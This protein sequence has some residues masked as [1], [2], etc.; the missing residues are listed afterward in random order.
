MKESEI[1][2][3]LAKKL[4]LLDPSLS[5]VKEEY[6]IKLLDGRRG[7]IDILA[8][9]KYGCYT[10]IE[11]KKSNKSA[12]TTVQQMY[13]Y[14]SF[15]KEKNRLETSQI[16]LIVISTVWEELSSPFS[17][18]KHFCDY[19]CLGYKL[20]FDV[21]L[22]PNLEK[23]DPEFVTGNN[24][25]LNNFI[26]ISY[27][28]KQ[29]RDNQLN[30]LVSFVRKVPSLNSVVFS[31]NL[32]KGKEF[33]AQAYGLNT[34][35]YGIAWVVFTSSSTEIDS[36]IEL[37]NLEEYEMDFYLQTIENDDQEF[38]S[39]TKILSYLISSKKISGGIS[40]YATHTL[41]NLDHVCDYDIEPI[42]TGTMF[43]DGLYTVGEAIDMA[44]GVN[45][46]HPYIF[47]VKTTPERSVHFNTIR[48]DIGDFL[49]HNKQWNESINYLLSDLDQ[50][51]EIHIQ[52]YNPLNVFG[53]F[54]DLCVAGE[55]QRI[56]HILAEV[57]K[58]S[59]EK[60]GFYGG[61]F[62]DNNQTLPEPVKAIE[63]SY[64]DIERFRIRSVIN[65]L[66]D[67]DENLSSLCGLYYHLINLSENTYYSLEKGAWSENDDKVKFTISDFVEANSS[68]VISV[69]DLYK[70]LEI[71]IGN[72]TNMVVTTPDS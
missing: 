28:E 7:F 35:Q 69:G 26:F 33:E 44:H 25:P 8:K 70:K 58:S 47:I 40:G 23:I 67:K 18:F 51:D 11:I 62:W 15:F 41:N 36:Q 9:D 63:D 57:V 64:E 50:E 42:L 54:N 53:F 56:P 38:T 12:R 29:E 45:G 1:R 22:N 6:P 72:K 14:A 24:K 60:V 5:L 10:I 30:R 66:T 39:R 49:K 61:L 55:S 71:G 59:G 4:N 17:E 32:S 21:G 65:T 43:E 3:L 48:K 34:H 31:L 19:D 68:F 2:T 13:K 46:L 27:K 16:R 37:L 20:I 52:I